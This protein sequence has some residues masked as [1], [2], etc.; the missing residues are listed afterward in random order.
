MSAINIALS[1]AIIEEGSV[2]SGWSI[3]MHEKD[4]TYGTQWRPMLDEKASR[5]LWEKLIILKFG[6]YNLLINSISNYVMMK[7]SIIYFDE[8]R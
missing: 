8:L 5:N 3:R 6:I 2:L 4:Q 1:Q 7:L